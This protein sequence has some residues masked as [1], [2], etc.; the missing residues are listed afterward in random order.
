MIVVEWRYL[1]RGRVIHALSPDPT[2][3][4]PA[5]CGVSPQWF[6]PDGWLGTA[7]Q[8]E[9]ERAAQLPRCPRCVRLLTADGHPPGADG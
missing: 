4:E 6:S 8:A 5:R 7:A 3:R 9:Y 1:S 2:E